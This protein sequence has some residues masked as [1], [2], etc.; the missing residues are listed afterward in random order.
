MATP[1]WIRGLAGSV[2]DTLRAAS[3][4]AHPE[5]AC[6]LLVGRREGPNVIVVEATVG[7]NL[8][9]QSRR[10]RFV[11]DPLHLM[12]V[13]TEA[14]TR[15]LDVVGTWHSHPDGPPRPSDLDRDAAWEG[16]PMVIA[17]GQGDRAELRAWVKRGAVMA[18][19]RVEELV[20]G[21]SGAPPARS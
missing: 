1:A 5:E 2:G 14:R 6:G 21:G 12:T 20:D 18:E 11:L 13:E 9:P 10:T 7:G 3:R 8:A 17:G 16:W 19:L 15:G 4:A